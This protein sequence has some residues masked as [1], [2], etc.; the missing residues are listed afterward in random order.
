M[1]QENQGGN[2]SKNK[3]YMI[4]GG[5]VVV[6]IV[7]GS[8]MRGLGR[9]LTG[10]NVDNN[11]NGSTTYSNS[12]GSVTVGGNKL[13]DNWPSDTPKYKNAQILSVVNSN[14]QTGEAGLAVSFSTSDSAQTVVDFYKK[15]LASNGWT[16]EQTVATEAGTIMAA[17][18]DNRNFGIYIINSEDGKVSVTVSISMP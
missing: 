18:K 5:V 10:G 16:V 17:T 2:L 7:G 8:L 15:E 4:I 1:E 12:D 13:P 9:S 11:I 14:P 3:L 6:L